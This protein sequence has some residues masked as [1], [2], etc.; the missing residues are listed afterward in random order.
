M[1]SELDNYLNR[2][3]DLHNQ[4]SGL[5]AELPSEA[6][7]WRPIEG[8]DDHATNSLAVLVAH[9]AGAEHFWIA[10]VIDGRPET[11]DRDAE[12]VT[13]AASATEIIRLLEKTAGET[14]E[15]FSTLNES[16]LNGTRQTKGRVVPV[17]WCI[18]HVIDHTSLH[19]GHM[20]ITYQLWAG[21]KSVPSP[22]WFDRLPKNQ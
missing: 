2:L 13:V 5:I 20:Q 6:L 10:E 9:L 7:N 19:L 14:R 22:L 16:D 18:L 15:V 11:R 1:I 8:K 12:F 3:D 17:R 4:I 21:G